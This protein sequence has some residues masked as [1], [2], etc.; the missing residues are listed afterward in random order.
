VAEVCEGSFQIRLPGVLKNYRVGSSPP[1]A[2]AAIA[3]RDVGSG[4]DFYLIRGGQIQLPGVAGGPQYCFD[5]HDVWDHQFIGGQGGP[6]P[7][8]RVQIFQCYASQL[9]QRWNLTG[10]IMSVGRCL[11]MSGNAAANGARAT[12]RTCDG[13]E[14]QDWDY[15][16]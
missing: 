15:Y 2:P 11:A 13:S 4:Q 12:V 14:V 5:V 3:P 8:Q 1:P 9:N 10:D 7:G 16:W 6:A